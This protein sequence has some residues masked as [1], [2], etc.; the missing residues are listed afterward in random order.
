LHR[1]DIS[2]IVEILKKAMSSIVRTPLGTALCRPSE[3]VL[4]LLPVPAL[5]PF[6]KEDGEVVRDSGARRGAAADGA[7]VS[8]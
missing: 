2:R 3:A 4:E 6:V 5:P 8:G 7:A 1:L